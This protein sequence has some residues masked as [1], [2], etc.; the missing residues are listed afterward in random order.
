MKAIAKSL[1]KH[2][3]QYYQAGAELPPMSETELSKLVAANVVNIEGGKVDPEPKVDANATPSDVKLADE[4]VKE[5]A[6][7]PISMTMKKTALIGIARANGLKVEKTA[8][9]GEVFKLIKEFREKE[10]IVIEAPKKEAKKEEKVEEAPV[11]ESNES[12]TPGADSTPEE[13]EEP[14]VEEPKVE[15]EPAKP[16]KTGKK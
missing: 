13:G 10:G 8:T 2:N 6:N 12:A 16:A 14:K 3:G 4:G 11:V 1:I 5:T 15:K 7:L 9:P